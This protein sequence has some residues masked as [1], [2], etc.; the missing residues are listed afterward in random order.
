MT[1]P[2]LEKAFAEVQKLPEDDQ[3]WLASWLL[4]LL[5][6]EAQWDEQFA[7]SQTVL[8][9]LAKEALEDLRAGRTELLDPDTL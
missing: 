6:D 7:R 5:E 8:E 4:E 1:T 2:L 9:Q 3:N